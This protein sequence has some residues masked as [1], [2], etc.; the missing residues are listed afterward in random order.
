MSDDPIVLLDHEFHFS[1]G[2][3]LYLTMTEGR[4]QFG[5]DDEHLIAVVLPDPQTTE[6]YTVVRAKVNYH[7]RTRRVIQ[8]ET[9][10]QTSFEPIG[11]TITPYR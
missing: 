2:D 3:P 6:E 9:Q 10:N 11:G 1:S 8:P 5:G 7:K 4:D